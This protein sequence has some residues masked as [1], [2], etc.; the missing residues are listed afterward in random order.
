MKSVVFSGVIEEGLGAPHHVREVNHWLHLYDQEFTDH[1]EYGTVLYSMEEIT[2]PL[3]QHRH[4][5]MGFGAWLHP[6]GRVPVRV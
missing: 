6:F 2:G 4:R 5:G 1:T 3:V